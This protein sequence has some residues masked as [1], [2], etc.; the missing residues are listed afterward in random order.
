M[1]PQGYTPAPEGTDPVEHWNT[2]NEARKARLETFEAD[3]LGTREGDAR[4][5]EM[6]ERVS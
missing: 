3:W 2:F 5:R 4:C 1:N 6:M